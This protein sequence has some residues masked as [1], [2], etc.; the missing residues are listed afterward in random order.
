MKGLE[1]SLAV[2]FSTA[3]FDPT[4]YRHF[5]KVNQD[6]PS[7]ASNQSQAPSE[8]QQDEQVVC[9]NSHTVEVFLIF[10]QDNPHEHSD[11]EAEWLDPAL[12]V[13]TFLLNDA[14]SVNSP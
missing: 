1:R 3:L 6:Q 9:A 12:K 10:S 5:L 13:S 11:T 4:S 2:C 7:G 14:S 8:G